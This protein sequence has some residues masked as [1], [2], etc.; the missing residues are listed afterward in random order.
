MRFA[1]LFILFATSALVGCGGSAPSP[2]YP[3]PLSPQWAAPAKFYRVSERCSQ[4]P[5]V[6][7]MPAL[8]STWGETVEIKAHGGAIA[9]SYDVWV[10]PERVQ[11]GSML[12]L[13][14]G[15]VLPAARAHCL[16]PSTPKP[17][18][19]GWSPQMPPSNPGGSLGGAGNMRH[20]GFISVERPGTLGNRSASMSFRKEVRV[21]GEVAL[22]AGAQITIV[23]Y[24]DLPNDFEN[25]VFEISHGALLPRD[26]EEYKNE[27]WT[28]KLRADSEQASAKLR[29]DA[30]HAALQERG[31]QCALN[32]DAACRAEGWRFASEVPPERPTAEWPGVGVSAGGAAPSQ[33]PTAPPPPARVEIVPPKPTVGS[34]WVNGYYVWDGYVWV[35]ASGAYRIPPEDL[36]PPPSAPPPPPVAEPQRPPSAG[37]L[38][39]WTAGRWVFTATGW[40]WLAGRFEL[41]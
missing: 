23:F 11:S 12:T 1:W 22:S 9:G 33:A 26:H 30:R 10:G 27:L 17:A 18:Q 25:V 14:G 29:A 20:T 5:L 24:S 28:A 36:R 37:P 35:W 4:G 8:G 38:A 32:M 39:Q 3:R 19:G 6:V 40:V 13:Y 31:R 34:V 16:L 41:R 7:T 21:W 2:A 15:H